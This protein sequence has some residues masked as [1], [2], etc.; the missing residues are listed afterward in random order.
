MF[1]HQIE[2]HLIS[3]TVA[4]GLSLYQAVKLSEANL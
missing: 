4:T 1:Y 3:W 2:M